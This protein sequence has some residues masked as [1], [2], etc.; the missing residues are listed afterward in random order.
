VRIPRVFSAV[1]YQF[2]AACVCVTVMGK[3]KKVSGNWTCAA[4]IPKPAS[5]PDLLLPYAAVLCC[6]IPGLK[7]GGG[8]GGGGGMVKGILYRKSFSIVGRME[9]E[10]YFFR[11]NLLYILR[12]TVL[13]LYR[14]CIILPKLGYSFCRA[15][16]CECVGVI[17]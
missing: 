3:K 13:V 8:G 7:G 12:V 2:A 9:T 15:R 1:S 10:I 6:A 5:F 17:L 16:G 14:Y 11:W 4:I